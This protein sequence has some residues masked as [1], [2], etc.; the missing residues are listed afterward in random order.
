MQAKLLYDALDNDFLLSETG[1]ESWYMPEIEA[2]VTR[3]FSEKSEGLVL[4][5]T[6]DI[7]K[8]YT[9]V[10]PDTDILENIINRGES[11]LLL[12]AHHPPIWTFSGGH[13]FMRTIP[14]ALVKQLQSMNIALYSLHIP[15]DH[16]GAYS[17]CYTF[18]GELEI[19]ITNDCFPYCGVNTGIIGVSPYTGLT[20]FYNHIEAKLKHPIKLYRYGSNNIENNKVAIVTGYGNELEVLEEVKHNTVNTFI[21]GFT[22]NVQGLSSSTNAHQF[23]EQ[24]GINLIGTTHYTSEKYACMK[25][26]QYYE[27]KG[28]MSEFIE[29]KPNLNDL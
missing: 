21:T 23:A 11:N 18:A 13:E 20:E 1:I 8:V 15:L 7:N 19:R 17:T 12:F 10:F 24:N 29:G 16:C 14:V 6:R 22:H 2:Y 5:F 28:L 26:V 4:D 3:T 9:M 27:K 25:M